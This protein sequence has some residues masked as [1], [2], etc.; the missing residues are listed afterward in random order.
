MAETLSLLDYVKSRDKDSDE[1]DTVVTPSLPTQPASQDGAGSMSLS[2]YTAKRD[3]DTTTTMFPE[4]EE[5][6]VDEDPTQIDF[7]TFGIPNP[8]ESPEPEVVPYDPSFRSGADRLAEAKE[9]SGYILVKDESG[10]DVGKLISEAT[11]E[12]V[13]AFGKVIA[14]D[15][16]GRNDV[17]IENCS[18][19]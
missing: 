14:K 19:K 5:E 15:T 18:F 1:E 4:V 3:G 6:E 13:A 9:Y 17:S 10:E 12:E 16:I 11:D 8:A 2:E 7:A